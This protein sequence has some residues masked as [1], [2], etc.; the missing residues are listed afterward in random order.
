MVRLLCMVV[1]QNCYTGNG[2]IY[3]S[4]LYVLDLYV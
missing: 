3:L 2:K 1:F 4:D